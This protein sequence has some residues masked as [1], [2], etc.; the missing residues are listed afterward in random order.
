LIAK[1]AAGGGHAGIALKMSRIPVVFLAVTALYYVSFKR[2][3]WEG[4]MNKFVATL[5]VLAGLGVLGSPA[6]AQGMGAPGG[7][8]SNMSTGGNHMGSAMSQEQFN[9]MQEYADTA[10]RLT[11][12]DKAKGKT[13]EQLLAE[14]KATVIGLAM[15]APLTCDVTEAMLIASGEGVIEG[16]T[17][18]TKTYEAGCTNGMGY[19][20]VVP[21]QGKPIGWSCFGADA[22]RIADIAAGRKP[23]PICQLPT[24]QNLKASAATVLTKA[25][26][27]CNVKGYRWA[28]QNGANHIEFDEFA[29]DDGKGYMAIVSLPG[30]SIPVNVETCNQSSA[31]G[32]PCK[33]SDNG[34]LP[35]TFKTLLEALAKHNV[36]CDA[37]EKTMRVIGQQAKLKRYVVEFQCTQ[38]PKGLVAVIPEAGSTSPFEA[39]DCNAAFKKFGAKCTLTPS[40]K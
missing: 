37:T 20:I 40:M 16:K 36:A 1:V 19:F 13:L 9:K 14:D 32:L 15:T 34:A 18:N 28:G 26:I 12:D 27:A 10:K 22:T 2:A 4:K 38:Q 35:V 31:R 24:N 6:M 3:V 5:A 11:K 25:G 33:L 23:G 8:P 39:V 21:D 29:C 17:T 7:T 30:A